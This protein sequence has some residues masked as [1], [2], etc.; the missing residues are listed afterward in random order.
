[1]GQ[2]LQGVCMKP[3][4]LF[5]FLCGIS[6][7]SVAQETNVLTVDDRAFCLSELE[8]LYRHSDQTEDFQL[9]P[10]SVIRAQLKVQDAI[11]EGLDTTA[12]YQREM[13]AYKRDLLFHRMTAEKVAYHE[14]GRKEKIRILQVIKP[15][16]QTLT[17]AAVAQ[18][19]QM[20]RSLH[21]ML[22]EIQGEDAFRK[23]AD[24]CSVLCTEEWVHRLDFPR[25]MEQRIF[26]LDIQEISP[27]FFSPWGIHIVQVLDK[28]EEE[29]DPWETASE[30][31]FLR[32]WREDQVEKLKKR[33]SFTLEEEGIHEL[34][35]NGY[36]SRE[37]FSYKGCSYTG[38]GFS[39]FQAHAPYSLRRQLELFIDHTLLSVE[40][41]EL[42]SGDMEYRMAVLNH[43]DSLLI[44]AITAKKLTP[45]LEDQAALQA[46]FEAHR[47]RY[48]WELPRF[49][50]VVLHTPTKKMTRE[51]KKFL[52]K[53]PEREWEEAITLTFDGE[54]A[55]RV[56]F[57]QGEYA[58]GQN[59]YVDK[60]LFK[61]GSFSPVKEYPFTTLIGKKVSG[62]ADWREIQERVVKEYAEELE[63]KWLKELCKKS[64]VEINEEVLKTVNNH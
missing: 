25:D 8:W 61:Q 13:A 16:P 43:S 23:A 12:A 58:I 2:N 36:T 20:M 40:A 11:R 52:K 60:L 34:F 7:F 10:E 49:R 35:L 19:E 57:E 6:F 17:R 29:T 31:S 37:L 4:C 62:P 30:A 14:A 45:L 47:S 1:M 32:Q 55:P 54:R 9:F 42:M 39:D 44:R 21:Q 51:V 27:P 50:G 64:V 59:P 63:I 56:C 3:W 28:Q 46:Y 18:A 15:L 24:S 26:S 41:T 33:H 38:T 53:I 22:T 48:K 5:A